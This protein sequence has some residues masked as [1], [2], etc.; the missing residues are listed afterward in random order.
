MELEKTK[1]RRRGEEEEEEEE[2]EERDEET[3]S[4]FTPFL[5]SYRSWLKVL[6]TV[7]TDV[8]HCAAAEQRRFMNDVLREDT[9][10]FEL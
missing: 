4:S 6:H 5:S 10:A 7:V 2:E 3:S 9:K 1:R 8:A